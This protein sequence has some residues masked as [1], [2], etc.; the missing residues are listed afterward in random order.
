VNDEMVDY[1]AIAM[2]KLEKHF[3]QEIE[4]FDKLYAK[5]KANIITEDETSEL[6]SLDLKLKG[7]WGQYTLHYRGIWIFLTAEQKRELIA[8]AKE[9][10]TTGRN[11]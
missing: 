6:N 8:T 4:T 11:R 9:R 10:K 5:E 1:E 2:A 7:L 3:P